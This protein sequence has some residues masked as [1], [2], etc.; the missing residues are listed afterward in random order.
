[1]VRKL[2][3]D[4]ADAL[5]KMTG[6]D[7]SGEPLTVERIR[8]RGVTALWEEKIFFKQDDVQKYSTTRS[9]VD[10]G[11]SPIG[12]WESPAAP[13]TALSLAQS[14]VA[15]KVWDLPSVNPQPGAEINGWYFS[16]REAKGNLIVSSN[17][18]VLMKMSDV[19]MHLRRI[20][21]DLLDS[22]S[23]AAVSCRLTLTP[24]G[25]NWVVASASILNEGSRD[26]MIPNPFTLKGAN[27]DFI[28]F[29]IGA[30]P[31][32]QE[33]ITGSDVQYTP[34]QTS[35]PKLLA[36]PWDGDYIEM[37]ANESLVFPFQ[38]SIDV[39]RHKGYFVR[40]VFSHFGTAETNPGLPLVRGR[41]FS[42]EVVI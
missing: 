8:L 22:K 7:I 21:N 12:I 26:C 40:A 16:T 4:I 23:G 9:F 30:P 39:S 15:A 34:I 17:P 31:V 6:G 29:E 33:G 19:D 10:A 41:V 1:M 27:T 42:N 37:L 24:S 14:L 11:G 20:A 35:A 32:R 18:A 13:R 38:P 25:G 5:R 3:G 36:P 2:E 28:Q